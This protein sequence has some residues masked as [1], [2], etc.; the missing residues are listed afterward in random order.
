ML[1]LLF[2]N[3]YPAILVLTILLSP[4]ILSLASNQGKKAKQSF[5][6]LF[7]SIL[8]FQIFLGYLNWENIPYH[9]LYLGL[10][11]FISILQVALLLKN[12]SF[13]SATVILNFANTILIF[14]GMFEVSKILGYQVVSL[15]SIGSVFLVLLGNVVG[16]VFINKKLS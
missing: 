4:F 6:L 2:S 7:I 3:P 12:E 13:N 15:P 9:S 16:L 8:S 14:T 5:K 11:F 1:E 10:F